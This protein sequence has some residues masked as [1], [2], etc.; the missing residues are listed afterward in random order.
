MTFAEQLKKARK[1][2]GLTQ[3]QLA[4]MALIPKRTIE[5]WES[6]KKSGRAPAEW[7]QRLV[8]GE[9]ERIKNAENV[10]R[11]CAYLIETGQ[12]EKLQ[13]VTGMDTAPSIVIERIMKG[14][15]QN[16]CK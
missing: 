9:I 2:A 4:D 3:Q 10:E 8:L 6:E 12:D 13:E 5:N 11:L 16:V 14:S 15:E 1:S 7:C